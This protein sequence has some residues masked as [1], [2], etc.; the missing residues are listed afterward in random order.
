VFIQREAEIYDQHEAMPGGWRGYRRFIVRRKVRESE[1]VTSFYLSPADGGALAAFNPGQYIT[2]KIEHPTTPT[3]PRNYSLSDRPGLPYYRISVKRESSLTETAPAG[4]VSNYL[5]DHADE[6]SAIDIGPP[7]GEF[8]LD[9]AQRFDRPIVLV[10][11]GIGM[12][13][14]LAM[15]KSLAHAG[16]ETPIYFVHAARNSR[17]HALAGEVRRIAA[18]CP[19]V[20]THFRYDAPLPDDVS[21][22]RCDSTGLVGCSL[23]RSLL[24]TND[25]EFYFC[26]PKPFM[27]SLFHGL[28][29]WG[30]EESRIHFEF[31]GPRQELTAVSA[32]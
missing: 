9:P 10:S 13:P 29:A 23:L 15:L 7:C 1:V 21:T 17:V 3:A 20:H 25:A 22:G 19:N 18:D 28:K 4:I 5:H 8:T 24:P 12:T 26:G 16:A 27:A 11:G 6:G 30:V 2:V 32:A 31:F 14:L